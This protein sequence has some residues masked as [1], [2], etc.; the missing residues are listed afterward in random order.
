M[1]K[2]FRG[3]HAGRILKMALLPRLVAHPAGKAVIA[4]LQ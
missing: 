1:G 2:S 4:R 3:G